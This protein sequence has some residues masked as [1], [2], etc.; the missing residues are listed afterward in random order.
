M[1]LSMIDGEP[2]TVGLVVQLPR[3]RSPVPKDSGQNSVALA[4]I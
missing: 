3:G 4:S 2:Q 1:D